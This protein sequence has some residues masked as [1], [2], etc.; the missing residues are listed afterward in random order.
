MTGATNATATAGRSAPPR[1]APTD[2]CPTETPHVDC[3]PPDDDISSGELPDTTP[4]YTIMHFDLDTHE[5]ERRLRECLDAPRVKI[6]LWEF[7]QWLRDQLKYHER[8]DAEGLQ[9]ARDRLGAV[10]GEHGID[11]DDE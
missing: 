6:A 7:D 11:L 1:E 8:D 4:V 3:T 10:F 9:A 5:G 2:Y